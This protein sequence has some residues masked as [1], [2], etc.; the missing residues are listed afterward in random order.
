MGLRWRCTREVGRDVYE[1]SANGL[2]YGDRKVLC[3]CLIIRQSLIYMCIHVGM[4]FMPRILHGL[5][6]LV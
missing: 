6:T 3:A 2:V 4:V 1:E 5:L